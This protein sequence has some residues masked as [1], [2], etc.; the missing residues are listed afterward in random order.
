MCSISVWSNKI[1]EHTVKSYLNISSVQVEDGGL[2][3]CSIDEDQ[4]P[5]RHQRSTASSRQHC[6]RLNVYGKN[7]E[8]LIKLIFVKF[9]DEWK[10]VNCGR[11][12][13]ISGGELRLLPSEPQRQ[14]LIVPEIIRVD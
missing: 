10:N 11:Q 6:A 4:V 9:L 3:C 12:M 8:I 13:V 1:D 5:A 14:R 2:Y 7:L